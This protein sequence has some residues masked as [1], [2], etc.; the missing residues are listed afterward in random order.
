[1]NK[2]STVHKADIIG[3]VSSSICLIH[4]IGTPLLIAFGAGFVANSMFTYFFLIISFVAIFKSTENSTN[5][6]LSCILWCSFLGFLISTLF[7]EKYY[8]LH[9]AGY[10]FTILIIV[11]HLLNIRHCRQ[12]SNH[13]HNKNDK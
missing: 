1:M 2:Q 9:Y 4:C 13:N 11:T 10:F 8:W 7:E 6:I 12:C 5:K 3:I